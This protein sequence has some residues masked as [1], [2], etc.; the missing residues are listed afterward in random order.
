MP[1]LWLGCFSA[2]VQRLHYVLYITLEFSGWPSCLRFVLAVSFREGDPLLAFLGG[3]L[4][5][6]R[7]YW[8]RNYRSGNSDCIETPTH[9]VHHPR[10]LFRS[11]RGDERCLRTRVPVPLRW[12][13]RIWSR[14]CVHLMG[15]RSITDISGIDMLP[16]W[17]R[18]LCFS[19]VE[20][21]RTC[22]GQPDELPG[23]HC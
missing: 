2:W 9:D 13:E 23:H 7:L 19:K 1:H 20:D 17:P 15:R 10:M 18:W 21:G 12:R 5:S 6:E 14:A 3:E 4:E 22:D 16:I 11:P 8:N